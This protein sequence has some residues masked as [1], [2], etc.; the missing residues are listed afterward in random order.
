MKFK[1]LILS[2]FTAST[3]FSQKVDLDKFSIVHTHRQLPTAVVDTNYKTYSIEA[4]ST[5][6]ISYATVTLPSGNDIN[7]VGLKKLSYGGHYQL[8]LTFVDARIDGNGQEEKKNEER[9]KDGTILKTTY[10]YRPYIDYS[11]TFKAELFDYKGAKLGVVNNHVVSKKRNFP[12]NGDYYSSRGECDSYYYNNYKSIFKT[13][14]NSEYTAHINETQAAANK[15]IGF[16]VI[17]ENYW[18]WMNDSKKHPEYEKQQAIIADFKVWAQQ[19]RGDQALTTDQVAKAQEFLDYFESLKKKYATEDK[20]DKKLRYSAFFNKAII[21]LYY[22]DNPA[23]A[24]E[25][26]AGLIANEYDERDG[27]QIQSWSDA[28]KMS[29]DKAKKKSRHFDIDLSNV[30]GP[31]E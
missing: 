1:S 7:I 10:A 24:Y 6:E 28:I 29:M 21:Y 22:L 11:L 9:A 4:P 17:S 8:R 26:G 12:T 5:G 2:L 27:K 16:E 30:K 15:M 14:I 13:I 23:K 25:E 31:N 19:V 18:L 3:L 20:A